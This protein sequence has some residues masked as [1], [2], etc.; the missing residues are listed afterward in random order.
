MRLFQFKATALAAAVMLFPAMALA[1]HPDSEA[2]RDALSTQSFPL[3]HRL[4]RPHPDDYKWEQVP[5]LTSLWHARRR[6]SE[7]N[8]PIFFF[9]TGGAGFNDPLGNC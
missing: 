3:L 9:G 6:A 5:W 1:Q 2:T 8:K 7:E 4:I